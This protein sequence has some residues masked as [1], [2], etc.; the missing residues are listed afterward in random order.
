M[1]IKIADRVA[2]M[3]PSVTLAIDSKAKEM[4]ANGID[5]VNFGAGEPDFDTPEAVK[6]ACIAA[7]KAG[8]TK[9]C[10]AS[11][12][13]ELKNA[14]TDKLMRDNGLSYKPSQITVN[15]GGKH[16]L[17]NAIMSLIN[18]GDEVIIPAPYW[19]S[20]YEMVRGAQGIP[21]VLPADASTEFKITPGQL[22]AA[23]TPKTVAVLIN[24]PSNP[25]GA[26]YTGQELEALAKVIVEK[27]IFCI[28]DE[29]YEKM[30]YDG[31]KHVSIA[32]F[33]GMYERTLTINGFSKAYSMTGWRLGYAAGPQ[34]LINAINNLQSHST[35]NA[36]T[37]VQYAALE[38]L[39]L[40]C[41]VLNAF[42]TAF[43]NRRKYVLELL[44]ELPD[45]KC[46]IPKGAFYVFPDFSAYYGK[47]FK[48]K[49]IK[50]SLDFAE[51]I[52]EEANV[53][54]VPGAAFGIDAY[55]RISYATAEAKLKEGI[56]RIGEAL[57]KLES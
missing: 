2:A 13:P 54:I 25:T 49:K 10:A 38:A 5:V 20:Y 8:K 51:Y 16:S 40:P 32:T 50:N 23:V 31:V 12:L 45:V 27:D 22:A 47:S 41:E 56:R 37:F 57:K 43:D 34:V 52:L 53:G 1:N 6:E 21:V 11:G 48:G 55:Q 14:L 9:Y 15:V 44:K 18:P 7:L 26:V 39:K 17:Y 35:S 28:S 29:L 46:A 4:Q 33:P 3:A 24:S 42:I 30:V 19:V 36:T